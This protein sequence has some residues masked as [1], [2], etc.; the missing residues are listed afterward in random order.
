M[1]D[2]EIAAEEKADQKAIKDA[3]DRARRRALPWWIFGTMMICAV[4]LVVGFVISNAITERDRETDR[5]NVAQ[6]QASE[7]AVTIDQ[8]CARNDETAR[9]LRGAG[10]C[11]KAKQVQASQGAKGEPGDPGL[12]G[13]KGEPG[14]PGQQGETGPSGPPGPSGPTGPPGAP[15]QS[16]A[17]GGDGQNG[18]E[19]APG[20]PGNDSTVPGPPGPTGPAG[21]AG[22][23]G[24]SGRPGAT[25]TD[26]A[27]VDG[28]LVLQLSDGTSVTVDG[29]TVCKPSQPGSPAETGR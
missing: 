20:A 21:P 29:S 3:G 2:E 8:L 19:G 22:P 23:P 16:G 18:A 7:Q 26:A 28:A 4:I 13:E 9:T 10:L 15:G 24:A 1:T 11:D 12:P 6:Q 5:A 14:I 25:I 27:C 17:P